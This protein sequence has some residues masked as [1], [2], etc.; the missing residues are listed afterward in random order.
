MNKTLVMKNFR[1]SALLA[2]ALLTACVF[3]GSACERIGKQKDDGDNT[4]KPL[5]L[6]TRSSE[7]IEKGNAFAM[8]F[9]ERINAE[10]E[11]DYVISP[12]SMQFLLGLLLDG[13]QGE[14]AAEIAGVLGYGAGETEAVDEHNLLLLEQLPGLDKKTT[15]NI[16]SAIFVDD[17]WPLLESY[18][19]RVGKYYQA[20]VDNL[21]FSNGAY[22]LKIINGWCSD[23]TNKLIPKVL[24]KVEPEMLAYLLN[25]LYFK[26]QWTDKFQA[27]Q[28]KDRPFTD[29]AGRTGSVPMM[30]QTHEFAYAEN[31][32][33]QAVRLPYGNGAFSMTVL[34]PK[35]GVKLS[36]VVKDV[37]NAGWDAVRKQLWSREVDLW[38][39]KFETK[40]K[41]NL[42]DILSEMGMPRAFDDVLADFKAMSAYALCL[43]FVQQ[44][45]IIK[46]D[47][48]GSEAAAISSAGMMKATSVGPSYPVVFHADHPFIYLISENRSGAILFAGRYGGVK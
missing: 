18:K 19:S 40:Y 42:N 43:S 13:A 23:H 30:Q 41:I 36:T 45:A 27:S 7:F 17:G 14:T 4:L 10:A 46:V 12:L 1:L 29:E 11:G 34:L 22:S 32:R 37:K 2:A 28:T 38:L 21:D 9:L 6:T 48:E 26:S 24:D 33:Y 44:D 8:D 31:E 20:T 5:T 35:A 15:L 3:A 47:E 39:P 16:A 25:A